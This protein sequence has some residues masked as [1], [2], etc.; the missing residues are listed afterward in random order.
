MDVTKDIMYET[1]TD[2]Q[3][4]FIQLSYLNTPIAEVRLMPGWLKGKKIEECFKVF[5]CEDHP[6]DYLWINKKKGRM[7]G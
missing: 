5:Y 6:V 1:G 3:G 7:K 2:K 4:E